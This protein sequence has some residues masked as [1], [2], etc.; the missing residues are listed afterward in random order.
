[1]LIE[2]MK[3]KITFAKITQKNL[4]YEGSITIDEAWM[5]QAK[6]IPNEKV[7]VVNLNNGERLETYVIPGK[8]GTGIIGLNGAAAR[9]GEIGDDL[10]IISYALID[11]LKESIEPILVNVKGQ[12]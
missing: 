7:Q 2:C 6:L 3:S 1:M 8:P 10:F 11:P 4:F 5:K 9:K 12:R